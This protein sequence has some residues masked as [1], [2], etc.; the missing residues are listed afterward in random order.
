MGGSPMLFLDNLN[1]FAVRSDLLASSITERPA[2]IRVLGR[3]ARFIHRDWA[4]VSKSDPRVLRDYATIFGSTRL[5][6]LGTAL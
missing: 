3:S 4:F 5:F 2:R 6:L 1:N